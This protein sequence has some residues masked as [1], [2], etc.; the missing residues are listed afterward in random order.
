MCGYELTSYARR[1]VVEA[2]AAKNRDTRRRER[3][4]ELCD[5]SSRPDAERRCRAKPQAWRARLASVERPKQDE[6][7]GFVLV[8]PLRPMRAS[9]ARLAAWRGIFVQR[10]IQSGRVAQFALPLP[11]SG[12]TVFRRDSFDRDSPGLARE[13]VQDGSRWPTTPCAL[14]LKEPHHDDAISDVL[15]RLD[16]ATA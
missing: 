16:G 15:C 1:I 8:R 6:P 3:Q 12:V 14:R 7:P 2:V 4:R 13:R 9:R 10:R 5:P 11:H